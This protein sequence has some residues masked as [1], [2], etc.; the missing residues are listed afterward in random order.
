MASTVVV[1]VLTTGC[2]PDRGSRIPAALRAE[3]VTLAKSE[4]L[5]NGGNAGS[6]DEVLGCVEVDASGRA[7]SVV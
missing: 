2:D 4:F 6:P 7:G 3:G 1:S 5:S